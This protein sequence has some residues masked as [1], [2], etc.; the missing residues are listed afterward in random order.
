MLGSDL[1]KNELYGVPVRAHRTCQW[2]TTD[3][4]QR[5]QGILELCLSRA[6]LELRKSS[7]GASL[8]FLSIDFDLR[9]R[10]TAKVSYI[11]QR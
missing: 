1:F 6:P 3:S 9:A 10:G 4:D 8:E 5:A 11:S 2:A 7:V